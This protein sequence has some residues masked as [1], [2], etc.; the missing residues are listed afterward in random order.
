MKRNMPKIVLGGGFLALT[1][2]ICII[3]AFVL[4]E[5]NFLSRENAGLYPRN[6]QLPL[7]NCVGGEDATRTFP[8]K[9][10]RASEIAIL[11]YHRIVKEKHIGK[12]HIIDGKVNPMVVAKE[13][14]EKQMAYLKEN[15]F[16]TLTLPELY[17]FLNGELDIPKKSVVLT[18][19][20][21]Y[22]DNFIEAY[23]ILKKHDF[24]A[25]NFVITGAVT[26]RSHLFKPRELQ[27]LSAKEIENA[28]DVFG[29]QS[30]TYN[31]HK[32]EDNDVGEE[33]SFLISR[34]ED[35]IRNDLQK[36]ITNLNGEQLGFAYPYG[37]YAPSTIN[38]LKDLG[39]KMAVTTEDRAASP[40][41]HIYEI[42]RFNVLAETDF[43]T[44]KEYV[45]R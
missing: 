42:P 23:P 39:F 29:F 27:Y 15:D 19:D 8:I 4:I 9:G 11:T 26:K 18:F 41:D 10:K 12:E 17:L 20:D 40:N 7:E 14:F 13:E 22:K 24:L 33:V 43:K 31:Y 1:S 3:I 28:C 30:H 21:G 44:F 6:A 38:I 32:R 37:E 16:V 2:L 36:S 45:N 34:S 25:T 35:K 5:Y